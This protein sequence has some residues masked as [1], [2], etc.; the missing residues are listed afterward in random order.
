MVV[1]SSANYPAPPFVVTIGAVG[2]EAVE[3]TGVSGTTW[4]IVRGYAG[5]TALSYL[6]AATVSGPVTANVEF[7]PATPATSVQA[8]VVD[9]CTDSPIYNASTCFTPTGMLIGASGGS[10]LAFGTTGTGFPP[11]GISA[12]LFNLTYSR[13][14]NTSRN[15]ILI[16]N[17]GTGYA[18][19]AAG[20][21]TAAI[22]S[23][24]AT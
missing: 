1:N 6:N 20:T 11:T 7:V 15:D 9:F 5:T 2:S 22:V 13:A 12:S 24:V 17:N 21:L 23:T 19:T 16:G 10:S 14:N 8:I 3:V 4:T 18:P